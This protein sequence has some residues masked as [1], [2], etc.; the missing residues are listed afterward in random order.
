[1]TTTTVP[2]AGVDPVPYADVAP[3]A[4]A[5]VADVPPP[6]AAPVK[7]ARLLSLDAFR[8]LTIGAM[9]LANNPGSWGH[10]YA[11]LE[12]ADW[13]G[14]TPTDLIF[15]FFL[16][17]VGV[18][19]PFSFGARAARGATRGELAAGVVVRAVSLVFLGML[20]YSVPTRLPGELPPG[21]AGLRA[22]QIL[23]LGF[24]AVG[25]V[26]LLWPWRT[27]RNAAGATAGVVLAWVALYFAVGWAVGS[28]RES[29]PKGYDFG[30]GL[31]NPFDFSDP[32]KPRGMRFPGVLQRI[33][34]CYL[35]VGLLALVRVRGVAVVAAVACCA[36]Y[37]ALMMTASLPLE[38]LKGDRSAWSVPGSFA[39]KTNLA[40]A[41]DLNVLGPHVY[42][43]YPDP[44]GLLSTLPAI[45]TALIG[46]MAGRWLKRDDRPPIDRAAGL[47][48]AGV[49]MAIAGALLG[50]WTAPV[51][52]KIWT[53]AFAVFTPGLGCLALGAMYYLIDVRGRRAWA[54]P[55]VVLGTN[56]ILVFLLSG[57]VGRT[58]GMTYVPST[59]L[60]PKEVVAAPDSAAIAPAVTAAT[61]PPPAYVGVRPAFAGWTTYLQHRITPPQWRSAEAVS[62]AYAIGFLLVIWLVM[63]VLYKLRWF[64]KV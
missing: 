52:K 41:V 16:F 24:P 11:P 39:E 61:A 34:A 32:D 25:F 20:L 54:W 57:V 10:I 47:L 38:P 58:M 29:L 26:L 44:E 14:W 21:H 6:L 31:L 35:V 27:S 15:P 50:Y 12:H 1:M 30:T 23:A 46:L 49:G 64:V 55:L 63:A 53:P 19:I 60:A 59:W 42:G 18:A 48:V 13:H 28:A 5:A 3:A 40:R 2:E 9:T 56:A 22:L 33:G 62:L 8:G 7:P 43:E 36:G 4:S 51:N 17:I 37:L 45:A